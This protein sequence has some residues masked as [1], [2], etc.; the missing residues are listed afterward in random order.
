MSTTDVRSDAPLSAAAPAGAT[1]SPRL[2]RRIDG[3]LLL[4][5]PRALSSNAALQSAKRL[6]RADKS[7]E[8]LA[9]LEGVDDSQEAE[10]AEAEY[11]RGLVQEDT[12][13][14]AEAALA[15][16]RTVARYPGREV[17]ASALCG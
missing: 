9:A 7:R 12:G 1:H 2:R 14:L 10:A 16:E 4:D 13:Q 6:Y 17:A 8:A 11:L 3:I 5:K 15:W